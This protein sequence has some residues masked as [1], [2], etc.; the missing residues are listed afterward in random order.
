MLIK[1]ALMA[2][3]WT[4]I[5][6]PCIVFRKESEYDTPGAQFWAKT[7]NIDKEYEVLMK[8]AAVAPIWL[9]ICVSCIVFRE[10]SDYDTPRA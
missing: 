3:I 2:P 9:K 10:E 6:V 1:R 8:W 7:T 5:C 4:K